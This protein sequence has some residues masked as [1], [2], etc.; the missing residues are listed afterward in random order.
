MNINKDNSNEKMEGNRGN[1]PQLIKAIYDKA[2]ANLIL[3]SEKLK[4]ISLR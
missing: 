3:N 2:T 4:A 1:I